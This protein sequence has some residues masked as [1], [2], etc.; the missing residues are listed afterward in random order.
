MSVARAAI[1]VFAG[2]VGV[3][4]AVSALPRFR[5]P[6]LSRRLTPYL[7]ALDPRRSDLLASSRSHSGWVS[8]FE[9]WRET[10]AA[11]LQRLLDDGRELSQRL[12][13]AGSSL[14]PSG[15]RAEQVTWGI[16]GLVGGILLVL[17]LD[18]A[19][20]SLS[21]V[22]AVTMVAIAGCGGVAARDRALSRAVARRREAARLALPTIVDLVCL[23]VT[24]GE[25][26]RAALGF[27]AESADGPL[28]DE[29]R[30]ALRAARGGL[31]LT[32]AL[33][34]RARVLGLAAFDRFA[35]VVAA[36]HERGIPLADAL[37]SL[38][39]DL[40]EQEKRELIEV[41]GRKQISM[42]VPVVTLI[43]PVAIVFAFYPGVVAIRTLAR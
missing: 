10:M 16:V 20:R 31:P 27:V 35:D 37:R 22:S 34:A 23:A 7:G 18:V 9:P 40:R 30:A 36:S 1:V 24:A 3:V 12:D 41:A 19:G 8:V 11:R 32:D 17:S 5:R 43:L 6:V 21:P 39:F 4:L 25:S 26:L 13:G 29:L 42:L 15:F 2:L 14:D 28:A 33:E 38:A